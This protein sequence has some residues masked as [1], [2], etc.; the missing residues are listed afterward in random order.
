[1][2]NEQKRTW[3]LPVLNGRM[4]SPLMWAVLFALLVG[5]WAITGDIKGGSSLEGG[6]GESVAER[7]AKRADPADGA[8]DKGDKQE[9][10]AD[11]PFQVRTAEFP[12]RDF[13]ATLVVR[14]RTFADRQIEV[15]AE[16][17]GAI[18][19]LPVDKGA[20][21]KQGALLCELEP[22]AR[23]ANLLEASAA[24][25]QAEGDYKA[26]QTLVK[27]GHT[28]GLRVLQ[29]K[30]ALDRAKAA[31]A[32]MELDMKRT[33]IT[34]PF[35]GY[36]DEQPAKPGSYLAIGATCAKLVALDPLRVIGAVRERDVKKLKPGLQ[37]KA[38][39]VTGE[40]R[41][42]VIRF[43]SATAETETRTFRME[44]EIANPDGKL[45]SGVTTDIEIPLAPKK[46]MLLPPSILTLDDKGVVGVRAVN[47]KKQVEFW[48]VEILSE[49][50]E[51]IWV[52]ALPT[53][54][55][56]ITVGQ[57]FVK[58]GQVVALV[59][60]AKYGGNKPGS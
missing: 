36:V 53:E 42:G 31:K 35:D 5:V 10:K 37:G 19:A 47:A 8:E 44:L 46:G 50:P 11:A 17:A 1:M 48:P 32:R 56:I 58:P 38:R 7:M 18:N 51:G 2:A 23:E 12:V 27:R 59:P 33:R 40:E 43:I 57:D 15:R 29:N 4:P 41:Q 3:R 55:G 30:A 6:E 52:E 25:A 9:A 45:K 49:K 16:T 13:P 60:D 34:A 26:S 28:A 24:V 39:L 20:F 21:V 14:G 22:G 54:G